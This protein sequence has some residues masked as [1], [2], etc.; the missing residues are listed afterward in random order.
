MTIKQNKRKTTIF[1]KDKIITTYDKR[2]QY[3]LRLT[4]FNGKVWF[5]IFKLK[6]RLQIEW[7]LRIGK[8]W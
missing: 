6:N 1:N 2:K 5:N 4:F 8:E 7:G 3:T